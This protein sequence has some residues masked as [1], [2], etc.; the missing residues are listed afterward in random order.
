MIPLKDSE[1]SG[2]FPLVTTL[3]I[4][5][6]CFVFYLEYAA[7]DIDLFFAKYALIPSLIDWHNPATLI[8]FFTSMF[9]HGGL[10]HLLSNMWFLWIFGDNVEEA[11]GWLY[12]PVYLIGGIVGGLLQ[13]FLSPDSVIPIVGASGA[14]AA[15]L[16]AYFVLFPRHTIVTFVPIFFFLTLINVPAFLALGY[17]FFLQLFNGTTS[18]GVTSASEGGV[19]YFAHIGGFI[20][21][22]V[23]ALVLLPSIR[24][25]ERQHNP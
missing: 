15:V 7:R 18:L 5:I 9:L 12:L 19:A 2:K 25:Y 8:P 16:G 17:W 1:N 6:N 24:K 23:A 21:G 20:T 13:Y 14:I 22:I 3:L 10:F 11:F 4:L